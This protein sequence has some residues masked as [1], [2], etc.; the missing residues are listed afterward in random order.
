MVKISNIKR[1]AQY[2]RRKKA[3][4]KKLHLPNYVDN[5]NADPNPNDTKKGKS[6]P[7]NIS[8]GEIVVFD[9]GR[10]GKKAVFQGFSYV[11]ARKLK[12]G[13]Q[14]WRCARRNSKKCHAYIHVNESGVVIKDAD[15]HYP[16]NHESD[17]TLGARLKF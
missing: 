4:S 8:Y 3:G 14:V 5:P 15:D 10:G 7:K 16:H 6:I 11:T 9:S 12:N 2:I 17:A 13:T 1:N